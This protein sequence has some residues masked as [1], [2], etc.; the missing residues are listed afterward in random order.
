LDTARLVLDYFEVLVWPAVVAGLVATVLVLFRPQIAGLIPKL[1]KLALGPGSAQF[2]VAPQTAPE[3]EER[4]DEVPEKIA[5]VVRRDAE[6][7]NATTRAV[8]L[9]CTTVS[10]P[11]IS[12][13]SAR[14]FT[15][16]STV[17]R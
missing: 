5:E 14:R 16:L 10:Q 15:E 17:A 13:G 7:P 2:D 9:T 11:P 12:T 3:R 4:D 6:E 1:R 8:W